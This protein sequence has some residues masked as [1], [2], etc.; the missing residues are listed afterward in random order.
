MILNECYL[1]ERQRK[2][3]LNDYLQV[4]TALTPP[5]DAVNLLSLAA[6]FATDSLFLT[7]YNV[8]TSPTDIFTK[9]VQSSSSTALRTNGSREIFTSEENSLPD[10]TGDAA[11]TFTLFD[12]NGNMILKEKGTYAK[13]KERLKTKMETIPACVYMLHIIT[14]D[15]KYNLSQKMLLGN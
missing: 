5:Y 15:G 14:D 13:I 2:I 7:Y 9:R 3:I 4:P 10:I 11:I 1:I 6:R 8:N 12:T